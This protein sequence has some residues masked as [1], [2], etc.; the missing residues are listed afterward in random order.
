MLSVIYRHLQKFSFM[1]YWFLL[2]LKVEKMKFLINFVL[3]GM[4]RR[5]SKLCLPCMFSFPFKWKCNHF[6]NNKAFRKV[7]NCYDITHA[8]PAHTRTLFCPTSHV[9]S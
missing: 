9:G 7:L 4:L 1:L 8:P 3:I 2:L 6:N 5:T